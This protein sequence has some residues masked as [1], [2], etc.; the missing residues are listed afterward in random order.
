[1]PG[2]PNKGA[3]FEAQIAELLRA[4]GFRVEENPGAA[5]P[6]QTDLYA[7]ADGIDLLVEVKNRKRKVDISD[8]DSL[9]SR[10][11]RTTADVVGAIFT[12]SG[13]TSEATRAVVSD[14]TREILVFVRDEI[15]LIRARGL[16]FNELLKR[17]RDELRIQGRLWIGTS[18]DTDFVRVKLPVG[19]AKFRIDKS[20][21][22]LFVSDARWLP[23]SYALNLLECGWDT[24]DSGVVL[25]LR[26]SLTTKE[27]L[28]NILG[29]LHAKF[30]LSRDGMFS[31]KQSTRCWHGIGAA[32]LVRSIALWEERYPRFELR[33]A[34]HSETIH[35]FDSFRSGCLVL[36]SQHRLAGPQRTFLHS[37]ELAIHLP[38]VPVDMTPFLDLCRY[39]RNEWAQFE[40]WSRRS[41]YRRV[42]KR[43]ITL[44]VVG[45]VSN[46]LKYG[47]AEGEQ[48]RVITAVIAKNPFSGKKNLPKELQHEDSGSFLVGLTNPKL[49]LCA[50]R[51]WHDD[52]D[53]IDQYR[54]QGFEGRETY[55]E[56]LIRP[57][58]TWDNIVMDVRDSNET[59][60]DE[61][62]K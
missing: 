21:D 27:D 14:R 1:M 36:T 20:L 8:V 5:R 46:T 32:N 60:R 52:G 28:Q 4:A 24:A 30:G 3:K 42:L 48:E 23:F 18:L 26:L 45:V 62:N 9:R 40:P 61:P 15:D 10:L 34:H 53:V 6:R 43:P 56:R 41:S 2:T 51:D 35:Y 50:V 13:L 39:T 7:R 55:S 29:Y 57:F 22:S 17:K 31:I 58:K 44:N 33:G 12:N 37:S 38:G 11:G 19:V 47:D 16:N 59:S 49:L 25:P 54:L